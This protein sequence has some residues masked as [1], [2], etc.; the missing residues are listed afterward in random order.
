[1]KSEDKIVSALW[2]QPFDPSE[3]DVVVMNGVRKNPGSERSE[4]FDLLYKKSNIAL[5]HKTPW[6]GFIGQ[7][8]FAKGF[9]INE[10]RKV[11]SFLYIT[12]KEAGKKITD[13]K[14]KMREDFKKESLIFDESTEQ[15]ITRK[16]NPSM[17]WITVSAVI[18]I[19]ISL[20][21]LYI[22]SNE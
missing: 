19:I 5:G 13:Y 4:A 22:C 3:A 12:K 14:L 17:K 20:I 10:N 21:L 6:C 1:M 11:S 16:T 15:Y 9:I 18:L 2:Y 7:Y 8:F